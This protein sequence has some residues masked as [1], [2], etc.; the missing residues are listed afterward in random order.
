MNQHI[1]MAVGGS[2]ALVVAVTGIIS[3][4]DH[5]VP[6]VTVQPP[7]STAT[8]YQEL[9]SISDSIEAIVKDRDKQSE[10]HRKSTM[11]LGSVI[12]N[13]MILL[14]TNE[15]EM[16]WVAFKTNWSLSMTRGATNTNHMV[17]RY[18]E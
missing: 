9:K 4:N 8:M 18:M 10:Q 14:K 1:L 15:V 17:V 13:L 16:E 11:E 6:A 3:I 5:S 7:A 2:I 12:I